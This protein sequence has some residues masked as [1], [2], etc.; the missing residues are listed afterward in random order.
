M[1]QINTGL[2]IGLLLLLAG[3]LITLGSLSLQMQMTRIPP[4]R[5]TVTAPALP[6]LG[7]NISLD[8]TDAATHQAALARLHQTGFGWVRLRM[9][10]GALEQAPGRYEWAGSDALL[11]AIDH[12]GLVPVVVLDG[13][14]SWARAPQDQPPTANPL[15]PPADFQHFAAFAAAFATRYG[16]QVRFYQIWDEPN[17]APHWGNR[18]VEPVGYAQLLKQAAIAIR[19]VD[20]DAVIITAALAPTRDRGHTALDEPYFLQ[21]LYAAGAAPYFDVVAIQPFGFGHA[22]HDRRAR[23]DLLNFGRAQLVRQTMVAAGD[24]DTPIWAVRYGWQRQPGTPWAV[25]SEEQQRRFAIA[26]LTLA[27]QEWPWLT[28]MGW[29]IDQP[30]APLDD[31]S[32]GFALTPPLGAAF[33][34]WV[35]S[36]GEGN[37]AQGA[38]QSVADRQNPL[39]RVNSTRTWW[40]EGIGWLLLIMGVGWRI[41]VVGRSL[42]WRQLGVAYRSWPRWRQVGIWCGLGMIYYFAT[43]PGLILLCWLAVVLLLGW[44]PQVGLWLVAALLPFQAQHKEL[45]LGALAVA[46]TPS[47]AVLLCLALALGLTWRWGE[48]FRGRHPNILLI[49]SFKS[50]SPERFLYRWPTLSVLAL[51]WV[52]INL[53]S[54]RHVWHWPA[55]GAGLWDLVL[56]PLLGGWLVCQLITTPQQARRLLTAL[57]IGGVAVAVVGVGMWLRGN[58]TV[59]D[60]VLRLVGPYFSPN[61]AALYLERTLLIGLGLLS[62]NEQRRQVWLISGLLL[63]TVALYL[64]ASRG[65]WLLAMPVGLLCFG[66]LV[67]LGSAGGAWQRIKSRHRQWWLIGSLLFVGGVAGLLATS[68]ALT[69]RLTNS[70][71]LGQ[72]LLTWAATI[73]LWRDFPWL[74]VGPGGFFWR[75][76]AY[77]PLGA[78]DEPNLHHPHNLWLEFVSGWGLLGLI[79]LGLL[80]WFLGRLAWRSRRNLAIQPLQAGQAGLLAACAAALAHAQVDA[81][82]VLPDLA[83]WFWLGLA[84]L[85]RVRT[86]ESASRQGI[87]CRHEAKNVK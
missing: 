81:F 38:P 23:P 8:Q 34:E 71:S 45:T 62:W 6:F 40:V 27:R 65:A 35:R 79:W 33:Q 43:W 78:L 10:W 30:A 25:V 52:A 49:Q 84:L 60:G 74:G 75:Y 67:G 26:A 87:P 21:R 61:G 24:G 58:G 41:A 36:G 83:L 31:V 76:P 28:A 47:H 42:P 15:A 4:S 7:I 59:A 9:D 77:L 20:T 55:Y 56:L 32:W 53:L 5:Q 1:G 22:P 16:A 63:I 80:L 18:L 51:G 29:A 68:P 14:P 12:A 44:Q 19:T 17:I 57:F 72:R 48:A 73:E 46:V 50:A 11:Q 66:W 39:K 85:T 69:A 13:S 54:A 70:A 3:L 86:D 2:R 82:M 37:R 64:T